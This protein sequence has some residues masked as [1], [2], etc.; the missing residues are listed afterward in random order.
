[1]QGGNTNPGALVAFVGAAT[2]Q[3]AV[4]PSVLQRKPVPGVLIPTYS[5]VCIS[6]WPLGCYPLHF[7][8]S[9]AFFL[10][11]LAEF[12]LRLFAKENFYFIPFYVSDF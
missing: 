8:Y 12:C 1:M 11:I 4:S 2:C 7:G 9:K 3:A 10:E 6:E 5:Q